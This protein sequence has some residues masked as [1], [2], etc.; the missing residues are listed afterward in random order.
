MPNKDLPVAI[1]KTKNAFKQILNELCE[2]C[3]TQFYFHNT[4]EIHAHDGYECDQCHVYTCDQHS[5]G[6]NG[7]TYCYF[8][9]EALMYRIQRGGR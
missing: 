9:Y 7:Q 4:K 3:V 1:P 5:F 8:C 6:Y 2:T